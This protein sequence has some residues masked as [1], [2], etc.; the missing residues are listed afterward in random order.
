MCDP[1]GG[2]ATAMIMTAISTGLQM[3]ANNKKADYEQAVSEYNAREMENEATATRNAG[4]EQENDHRRQVR[5]MMSRQTAQAAARGVD[6]DTGSAL[7]L[8]EDTE[9]LGEVDALRIRSNAQ[10]QA[11]SMD[12]QSVLTINQG[13]AAKT[14]ARNNNTALGVSAIGSMATSFASYKAGKLGTKP[15]T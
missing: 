9:M 12:R 13:K 11:A 3:D 10:S 7:T 14:M 4:I 1:T 6:V 8:R 2:V 15:K 5:E